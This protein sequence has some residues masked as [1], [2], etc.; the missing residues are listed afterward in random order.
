M[1]GLFNE[2]DKARLSVRGISLPL[3]VFV[4]D[5]PDPGRVSKETQGESLYAFARANR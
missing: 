4:S 2:V 3:N 5:R 1:T